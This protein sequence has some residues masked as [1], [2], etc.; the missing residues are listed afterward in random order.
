MQILIVIM[1]EFKVVL[2]LM[3]RNHILLKSEQIPYSF[4]LYTPCLYNK[5]KKVHYYTGNRCLEK[6]IEYLKKHIEIIL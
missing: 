4:A 6:F 1:K 3:T 5:I 2:I